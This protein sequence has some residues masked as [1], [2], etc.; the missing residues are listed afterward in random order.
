MRSWLWIKPR[1][2][3]C[4]APVQLCCSWNVGRNCAPGKTGSWAAAGG[5][6]FA[7]QAFQTRIFILLPKLLK[8]KQKFLESPLSQQ[9][10]LLNLDSNVPQFRDYKWPK[11]LHWSQQKQGRRWKIIPKNTWKSISMS[12]KRC[13]CP[14]QCSVATLCSQK[15]NLFHPTVDQSNVCP[16]VLLSCVLEDLWFIPGCFCWDFYTWRSG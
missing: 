15:L 6:V 3:L 13:C 16:G 9:E 14:Q 1:F 2:G 4:Q 11:Q 10:M 12:Y 8:R 7:S 5:S